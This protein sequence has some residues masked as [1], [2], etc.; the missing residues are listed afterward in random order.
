M[1]NTVAQLV[2]NLLFR[3]GVFFFRRGVRED[4]LGH[5]LVPKISSG[6]KSR[7]EK[8]KGVNHEIANESKK[9]IDKKAHSRMVCFFGGVLSSLMGCFPL[10]AMALGFSPL[11]QGGEDVK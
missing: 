4:V 9:Q 7:L 1:P 10:S 8:T 11:E 2:I 6:S 5:F 3:R